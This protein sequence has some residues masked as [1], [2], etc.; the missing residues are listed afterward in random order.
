MLPREGEE[1]RYGNIVY[2][3]MPQITHWRNK[4]TFC[5]KHNIGVFFCRR[6]C[7][8]PLLDHQSTSNKPNGFV[9]WSESGLTRRQR[10]KMM[11]GIT[12]DLGSH[13][14]CW[15]VPGEP[16]ELCLWCCRLDVCFSGLDPDRVYQMPLEASKKY[17]LRKLTTEGQTLGKKYTT[18][19]YDSCIM[20]Q[21]AQI[22]QLGYI[23]LILPTT[24]L[25]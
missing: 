10:R 17:W 21:T 25:R 7:R 23:V 18:Q 20:A 4:A 3:F 24:N 15:T 1:I 12:E 9:Q 16:L 13:Q 6:S 8:T 22:L 19:T 5:L 14:C 2:L 11:F